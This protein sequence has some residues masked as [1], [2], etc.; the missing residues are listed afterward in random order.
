[1]PQHRVAPNVPA[2]LTTCLLAIAAAV[3]GACS[4]GSGTQGGNAGSGGTGGDPNSPAGQVEASKTPVSLSP[5][6][7]LLLLGVVLAE[8]I[9]ADRYL[10]SP[11]DG[12]ERA[13]EAA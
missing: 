9:V 11:A 2:S 7:L 8:S 13:K 3:G 12:Q 10:R 6:L 1:M 5:I 4:G